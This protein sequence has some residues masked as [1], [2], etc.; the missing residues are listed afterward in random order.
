MRN[1]MRLIPVV[2][3]L[4]LCGAWAVLFAGPDAYSQAVD[5][6]DDTDAVVRAGSVQY[7]VSL[8]SSGLDDLLDELAADHPALTTAGLAEAV[9]S[10]G[11]GAR[12]VVAVSLL[13]A[14]DDAPT[15]H[16]AIT[17]LALQAASARDAL[18]G[19]AES[20]SELPA[21]RAAALLA[22]GG[23]GAQ[24][25]SVLGKVVFD[26]DAPGCARHAALRS[27]ARISTDGATD[28]R[29]LAASP[30]HPWSLRRV[31]IL[32]LGDPRAPGDGPLGHLLT[33]REAPVRE[34]VLEAMVARGGATN[35]TLMA[36]R[37]ADLS[38]DVRLAA[39]RGLSLLGAVGP[40]RQAVIG[41]MLDADP[42]V[43]ALAA[44]LVGQTCSDIASTVRPSLVSLLASTSFH[45]RHKAALA[46]YAHG[47]GFGAATMKTDSASRNP[48]IRLQA[49][50]AYRQITGQ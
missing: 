15:R 43:K 49:S 5:D 34:A 46:L 11:I 17:I 22:L 7:L 26:E 32:A 31:A 14:S 12:D 18:E 48:S 8:G 36:G 2:I 35:L 20:D 29:D 50:Q 41:R 28:A 42:R 16:A 30:D 9:R 37:L 23:A 10:I 33:S 24:A 6:L 39:L 1:M 45:V 38:A 13:L 40:H 27:L 25:R 21:L 4:G 44:D 19:V 47:D 3:L